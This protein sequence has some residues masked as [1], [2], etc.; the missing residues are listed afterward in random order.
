MPTKERPARL[1]GAGPRRAAV[2]T[3]VSRGR[4]M[5][6]QSAGTDLIATV[7]AGLGLL[8]GVIIFV[9]SDMRSRIM[10]L[11]DHAFRKGKGG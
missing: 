4:G 1:A 3:N 7:G 6:A 5:L 2:V 9:L 11:E 10:R 8:Q